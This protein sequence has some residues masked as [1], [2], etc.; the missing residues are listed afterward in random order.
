[1]RTQRSA[2]EEERS[3]VEGVLPLERN[4]IQC[5]R[6]GQLVF[7]DAQLVV[8]PENDLVMK[9]FS[10]GVLSYVPVLNFLKCDNEV[11]PALRYPQQ[12]CDSSFTE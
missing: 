12:L 2:A 8:V 10:R 5:S 7:D 3:L 6:D 11:M 1:M 4:R 9:Y